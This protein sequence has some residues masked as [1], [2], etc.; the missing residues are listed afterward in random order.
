MLHPPTHRTERI[1]LYGDNGTGKSR[2]WMTIA[3]WIYK[4]KATAQMFVLDSD[5]AWDDAA[6]YDN[7][8]DSI[9]TV[10]PCPDW[11][12]IRTSI[13]KLQDVDASRDDWLVVDMMS[14]AWSFVRQG[15]FTKA[16]GK[17]IDEFFTIPTMEDR[18]RAL[19]GPYGTNWQAVNALYS[20]LSQL[21]S[22]RW[23]GHILCAT[24]EKK[25]WTDTP[26]G[27]EIATAMPKMAKIGFKPEGQGDF[28]GQMRT[29]LYLQ[30]SPSG[31]RYSTVKERN[32]IGLEEGDE[33]FRPYIDGGMMNDFVRDY[34]MKIAGWRP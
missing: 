15:Y 17:D 27:T 11:D 12:A 34:L 2:T 4:T 18:Q 8:L 13:R 21:I 20:P 6:P 3:E 19:S 1:G 9:V 26:E 7:H 25:I 24:T 5:R 30:V 28:A 23:P 16:F 29:L 31:W 32:P 10:F 22:S 33:G 14:R